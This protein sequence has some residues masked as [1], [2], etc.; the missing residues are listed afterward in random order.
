MI[1]GIEMSPFKSSITAG[2]N[3]KFLNLVFYILLRFY[4]IAL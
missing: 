1:S 3:R 4:E 2:E